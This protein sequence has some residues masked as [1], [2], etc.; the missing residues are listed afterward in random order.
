MNILYWLG[1]KLSCSQRRDPQIQQFKQDRSS[2]TWQSGG[3]REP[4][5][6]RKLCS[7]VFF[8]DLGLYIC[9]PLKAGPFLNGQSWLP[10]TSVF[11][12]IEKGREKWRPSNFLLSKLH[13]N[14]THHFSL[15]SIG[16]NLVTWASLVVQLVKNSSA[17]RETW[18]QPLD[19]EDPLEKG[20][21]THSSI[22]A[23][24]IPWAV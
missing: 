11:Q 5:V 21:A 3:R 6:S 13:G 12:S 15:D 18:V 19:W 23:W 1:F 22:P 24:R 7:T 16:N 10:I 20:M 8:K 14:Y 9:H 4:R 2:F 17:I